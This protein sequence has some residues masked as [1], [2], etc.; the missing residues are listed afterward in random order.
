MSQPCLFCSQL[1][2]APSVHVF[3]VLSLISTLLV[4]LQRAEPRE[5]FFSKSAKWSQSRRWLNVVLSNRQGFFL[6][7]WISQHPYKRHA[8]N[9]SL[10]EGCCAVSNCIW[11]SKSCIIKQFFWGLLLI[12]IYYKKK[13]LDILL[14]PSPWNGAWIVLT[15]Q[16]NTGIMQVLHSWCDNHR[17]ARLGNS[18]HTH[19][20]AHRERQRDRILYVQNHNII[21]GDNAQQ[22]NIRRDQD[23][24]YSVHSKHRIRDTQI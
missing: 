8:P 1:F 21:L 15:E 12:E 17:I 5:N 7:F 4:W 2:Q 23:M 11:E 22:A 6:F 9:I 13:K 18:T 19:T 16:G 3:C 14:L 10:P 24:L 20:H